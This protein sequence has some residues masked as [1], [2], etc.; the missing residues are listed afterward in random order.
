L[1][2]NPT[3]PEKRFWNR[4]RAQQLD[5]FRFR[6]QAP[7]GDY[8]VDFYCP[9]AKLIVELDGGQYDGRAGEDA[10]RT[11]WLEGKGFRVVRFWNNQVFENMNGVLE[12]LRGALRKR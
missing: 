6:R 11:A 4:V 12:S 5:G 3:E 1:R 7:I 10:V 9:E 8:V 2:K